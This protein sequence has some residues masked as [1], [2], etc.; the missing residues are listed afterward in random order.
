V[1]L[2]S[3]VYVCTKGINGAGSNVG[4]TVFGAVLALIGLAGAILFYRMA[5]TTPKAA[6]RRAHYI[7]I[8][9]FVVAGVILVALSRVL[10]VDPGLKAL[11]WLLFCVALWRLAQTR[12]QDAA[13]KKRSQDGAL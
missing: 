8:W 9:I 3:A 6:S 1:F 10:S 11:S 5:F 7:S 13:A 12:E 4:L 2:P